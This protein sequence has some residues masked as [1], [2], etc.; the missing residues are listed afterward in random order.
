[1][2][3]ENIAW[4]QGYR[5]C[6]TKLRRW[7]LTRRR[8]D[9]CFGDVGVNCIRCGACSRVACFAMTRDQDSYRRAVQ[10]HEG[11]LLLLT[12][13][14]LMSLQGRARVVLLI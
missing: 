3:G 8:K 10:A 4:L 14:C 6:S 12:V 2:F 9:L 5:R 7:W 13:K 1:M 11:K